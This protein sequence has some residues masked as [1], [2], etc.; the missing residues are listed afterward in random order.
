MSQA[1]ALTRCDGR[2][3]ARTTSDW[4]RAGWI[5]SSGETIVGGKTIHDHRAE[6]GHYCSWNCFSGTVAA[7]LDL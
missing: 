5:F 3:C 6:A 1:P 7:V 4:R 2:R